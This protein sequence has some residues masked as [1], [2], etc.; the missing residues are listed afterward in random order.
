M[1]AATHA[2]LPKDRCNMPVFDPRKVL[3]IVIFS[4]ALLV[5]GCV[6]AGKPSPSEVGNF[7]NNG[8]L[9]Q[10]SGAVEAYPPAGLPSQTM[11]VAPLFAEFYAMLGGMDVLGPVISPLFESGNLK[12][13]YVESGLMVF[14]ETATGNDRFRLASLGLEFVISN[15]ETPEPKQSGGRIIDG[16]LI[17][18]E[19]LLM[20]D[21]LGGARYVGRP[22][23]DVR[24]NPEKQRSEQYFENLGFYRLD[25][26]PPGVV[27]LMEYGAYACNLICRYSASSASV[28]LRRLVLPE[29]FESKVQQLGAAITGRMLAE[30]HRTVDGRQA[31]IF[32]N[33]VLVVDRKQPGGASLLPIVEMTGFQQQPLV[34]PQKNPLMTFYPIE[35]GLGHN[36][37]IYIEG[38]LK[39]FGGV[40]I[41][42]FPI[43]EVLAIAPGVY[44]QCFTNLCV[45]INLN[46]P[47]GEQLKI[48]PLGRK[49]KEM[50][51]DQAQSF[52]ASQSLVYVDL[53]IWEAASYISA[54]ESQVVHVA[55]FENGVP[56]R[57]RE[58]VLLLTLPDGSL[59]NMVFPPTGA[60]GRTSL[61]IPPIPASNQT[62]IAYRVCLYGLNG[63]IKYLDDHWQI[64]D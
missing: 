51:F 44:Q 25:Q 49:Y 3:S 33:L 19:F 48:S 26:D 59:L 29:A 61:E 54:K 45:E 46:L 30:P 24:Y 18:A 53:K 37:P 28:P 4:F 1:I 56:L 14:D 16:R 52:V 50:V 41:T 55:I 12:E 10:P 31:V 35:N 58:P 42:G 34:E 7:S 21:K 8:I 64:W 60:D 17:P 57:N 40:D 43:S 39:Q 22:L 32:E 20:Y 27:H 47:E 38:F 11:P 2:N 62:L 13:Q 6:E 36:V 23:T 5:S 15:P 63:E 9:G